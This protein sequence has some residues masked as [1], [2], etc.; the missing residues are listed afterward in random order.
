MK[1]NYN[2]DED[3]EHAELV[4][5]LAKVAQLA[6]DDDRLL[7]NKNKREGT[8]LDAPIPLTVR[9]A[10]VEMFGIS[11]SSMFVTMQWQPQKQLV[12]QLQRQLEMQLRIEMQL[13]M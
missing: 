2:D 6:G 12:S 3:S 4:M 13:R 1:S 10:Y 7:K 9:L 11:R 8:R 5:L